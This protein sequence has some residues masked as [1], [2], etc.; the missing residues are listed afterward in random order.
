MLDGSVIDGVVWC[1]LYDGCV[2]YV[3]SLLV[4]LSMCIPQQIGC[5]RWFIEEPT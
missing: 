3:N 2:E 1:V 4:A 5:W